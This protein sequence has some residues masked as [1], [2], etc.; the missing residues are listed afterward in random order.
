MP[1]GCSRCS[2]TRPRGSSR[3]EDIKNRSIKLADLGFY[4]GDGAG[5]VFTVDSPE[6]TLP[7]GADIVDVAGNAGLTA[8]C[9]SGTRVVG[10]G[11]NSSVGVASFVKSYELFVGTYMFNPT[12]I[13]IKVSVQAIC[14]YGWKGDLTALALR[15]DYK[16]DLAEAGQR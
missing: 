11:F 6:L 10:T 9:P 7:P 14:T 12:S 16:R 5:D 13:P 15:D 3:S 8:R 4:N 1:G 2:P